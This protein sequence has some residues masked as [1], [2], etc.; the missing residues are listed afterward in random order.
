MRQLDRF[1]R[2]LVE[3]LNPKTP[4]GAHERRF[5]YAS[6]D[7]NGNLVG[8]FACG[9][10]QGALILA[11]LAAGNAPRPGLA[12]DPDGVE[13]VL[14]DTRDLGQRNLDALTDCLALGAA[15]AGITLPAG[16]GTR[17]DPEPWPDTF[18]QPDERSPTSTSRTTRAGGG[19]RLPVVR[20][21]GVLSG[22]YPPVKI[23]VTVGV[24]QLA[25]ALAAAAGPVKDPN[26]AW[27][28]SDLSTKLPT[29]PPPTPPPLSE[30]VKR[31]AGRAW[32]QHAGH[33]PDQTLADLF[34]RARLQR[35]LHTGDGAVLALGRTVRLATPAQKDALIARDLG[36]VIPGCAVPGEHC[37]AHH[38]IPWAAGGP[39]DVQNMCLLCA[40]HHTEVGQ[41][42]WDI[43]MINGVPWVRPPSW[44]DHTRPLLAQPHPQAE[45]TPDQS[46]V[47]RARR[48]VLRV[49]RGRRPRCSRPA[50]RSRVGASLAPA[51]ASHTDSAEP[52]IVSSS[53]WHSA[54]SGGR[55][56]A[57][58]LPGSTSLVRQRDGCAHD[59]S[60]TTGGQKAPARPPGCRVGA[61][62][63]P[64]TG[65]SPVVGATPRARSEGPR[66][67][68]RIRAGRLTRTGNPPP[69]AAGCPRA[70]RST[71]HPPRRPGT[72]P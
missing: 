66:P 48:A 34:A 70:P 52:G 5:L 45:V 14:P 60:S 26:V 11:V 21:P 22:P 19:G 53:L 62:A 59:G 6:P 55:T 25:A 4:A 56:R 54:P 58:R 18:G 39:T 15:R 40:R 12:I 67:G 32:I 23:L 50:G 41:R 46:L 3:E 7:A 43:Q 47:D 44:V 20:E 61:A 37:E 24:E 13:R 71:A 30:T 64:T 68:T 9:A 17:P 33:P 16:A 69:R 57:G 27:S 42:T 10:T 29:E 2:A 72:E 65:A 8:K 31:V 1:A 51:A 28:F 49:S 63:R 35:V 38:V 36:C